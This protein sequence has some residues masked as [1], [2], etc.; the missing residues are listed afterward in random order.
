MPSKKSCSSNDIAVSCHTL[1]M[2]ARSR[3]Y[4]V[5]LPKVLQKAAPLFI[6]F[7]GSNQTQDT[8]MAVKWS[9]D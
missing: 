2:D 6:V 4:T 3:S 8:R 7:H 9:F 5:V 1:Q